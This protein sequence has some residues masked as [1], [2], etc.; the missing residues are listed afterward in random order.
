M[1]DWRYLCD[2]YA[3]MADAKKAMLSASIPELNFQ[4]IELRMKHLLVLEFESG[5][6]AGGKITDRLAILVSPVMAVVMMA[7]VWMMATYVMIPSQ[8]IWSIVDS[9][10]CIEPKA[11]HPQT[12]ASSPRS[13]NQAFHTPPPDSWPISPVTHYVHAAVY[14]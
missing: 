13:V 2:E 8:L 9:S 11:S 6:K 14:T 10:V 12:Q 7:D 3:C 1:S 5:C 4:I